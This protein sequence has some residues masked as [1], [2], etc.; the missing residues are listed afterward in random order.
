MYLLFIV[1]SEND[2][3][4]ILKKCFLKICFCLWGC[5]C[6]FIYMKVL[7]LEGVKMKKNGNYE[8]VKSLDFGFLIMEVIYSVN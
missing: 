1:K 6:V 4:E 3:L 2:Y 8:I 7:I 5:I